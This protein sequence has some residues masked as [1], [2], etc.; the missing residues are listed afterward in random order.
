MT[1]RVAP[2][3]PAS[4][5][6][7]AVRR[8][9]VAIVLVTLGAFGGWASLAPL[10]SAALAPGVIIVDGY[11]KTVQHL[12]GGIVKTIAVR[13]GQS[14]EKDDVLLT[15]DDTQPRAQLELLRGQ[16][17]I[18]A[19]REARLAAQRD[20]LDSVRY[21]TALHGNRGDARVRAAIAIQDQVFRVRKAAIDGEVALHR[22][23][24]D[25]LR[26][27]IEGLRAQ[28][29]SRER[30]VKSFEEEWRDFS[31]LLAEGYTE[32]QRVRDLERK[33]A[34]SEGERGELLA[35]IAEAQLRIGETELR[36]LQLQ[37]DFQREV[38]AE[39]TEVQAALFDLRQ[40][41][42]SLEDTV[43][44]T[45]IR[46]PE[47]GMVLALTVHT[48]GAV[49]P[50]GG[51]L[52]DIVPQHEQLIVEAQVSPLDIDRVKVGQGAEV[53]FTA[54]NSRE[55]PR[56]DGQLI[57][58]S[59]D[60]LVDDSGTDRKP[61]YLARV[62][63]EAA[64]LDILHAQQLELVP[65]MPAEVLINTGERTFLQYLLKPLRDSVARSLIED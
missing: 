48:I 44:R 22:R 53:R 6:D 14:V 11:R 54:F 64:G 8:L 60:R 31:S 55:T 1:A 4:G 59:A 26:A 30:L 35:N 65:G 34:Q 27:Q 63:V 58:V 56:I 9:G 2:I 10:S 17:I 49:V 21:P 25:Q 38:A 12:E 7:R 42:Q 28:R 40:R 13:D 33:L 29:A 47:A 36:I 32:K 23:Q 52:L 61:Y 50:P 37:K 62:E 45:V 39:L 43:R 19:A 41:M 3:R 16:Y 57:A 20:G 15:L 5:D 18:A 51:P 46:A 24:I